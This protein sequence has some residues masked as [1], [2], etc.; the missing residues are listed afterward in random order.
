MKRITHSITLVIVVA[1]TY[2]SFYS[3]V[4]KEISDLS[5]DETSFSTERA[6]LQLEVIAKA[7]H[8]VGTKAH[9]EVRAYILEE[10]RKLGLNPQVQE[11]F[12]FDNWRGYGNL[13]KPKNIL[14]RIP[15]TGNGKAIL[16][17]S[18]ARLPFTEHGYSGISTHR[19]SSEARPFCTF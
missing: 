4:P 10:L 6:M 12:T 7:P 3:L 5:A 11:G 16:F 2:L 17:I 18:N 19:S 15:G 9:T 14:A 8:F 1:L 13:V